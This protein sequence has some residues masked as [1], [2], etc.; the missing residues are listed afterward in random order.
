[1]KKIIKKIIKYFSPWID[2]N[3][4]IYSMYL[5]SKK[6]LNKCNYIAYYY[7]YKIEKKYGCALPPTAK[8]GKNLKFPHPNGVV[9]GEGAVVGNDVTIYQNVTLGRKEKDIDLYPII[10]N[11]VTIYA[12]SIIVGNVK[13]GNNAIIGCNSVVLRDVKENEV[14]AGIVK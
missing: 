10:G 2:R 11:N 9:I 13:I 14:V 7:S 4:K 3:K 6:W 5:K 12:N 1:M 8:I